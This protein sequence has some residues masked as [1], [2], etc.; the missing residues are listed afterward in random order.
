MQWEMCGMSEL[1]KTSDAPP[2]SKLGTVLAFSIITKLWSSC[3]AGYVASNPEKFRFWM[4]LPDIPVEGEPWEL[5]F[6]ASGVSQWEDI[7]REKI[8]FKAGWDAH[9]AHI[10]NYWLGEFRAVIQKP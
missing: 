3:H 10:Q 8:C 7:G 4:P 2:D 9:K 5:A 1:Y 6:A